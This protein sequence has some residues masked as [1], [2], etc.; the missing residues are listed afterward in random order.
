M[1]KELEGEAHGA[2]L[3][4]EFGKVMMIGYG[5]RSL[6]EGIESS[7]GDVNKGQSTY[8]YY[9]FPYLRPPKFYPSLTSIFISKFLS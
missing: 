9:F 1:G 3:W 4:E 2:R 5:S 6:G 7:W 8:Y